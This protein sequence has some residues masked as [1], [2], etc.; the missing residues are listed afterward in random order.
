[1]SSVIRGI[2][3]LIVD[4]TTLGVLTGILSIIKVCS[5]NSNSDDFKKNEDFF[6]HY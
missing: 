1:M 4:L 5:F 6:K 2:K 3:E